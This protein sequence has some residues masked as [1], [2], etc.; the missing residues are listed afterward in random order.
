MRVKI[1]GD[2]C[3]HVI[4]NL[5]SILEGIKLDSI[6]VSAGGSAANV[7]L[8]LKKLNKDVDFFGVVGKDPLGDIFCN[9]LKE[10]HIHTD[11]I[12]REGKTH[13]VLIG[14]NTPSEAKVVISPGIEDIKLIKKYINHVEDGDIVY[15]P[16]F[17]EYEDIL[18]D[19]S[20][21]N[22]T[23]FTDYGHLSLGLEA[24]STYLDGLI[25]ISEY[26]DVVLASGFEF[27]KNICDEIAVS[28]SGSRC[29]LVIITFAGDGIAVITPKYQTYYKTNKLPVM[30]NVGA[31]DSF[32]AAVIYGYIQKWEIDEI[33]EFAHKVAEYKISHFNNFAT[34]KNIMNRR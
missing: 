16:G 23:V 31:G 8:Q 15:I 17:K 3:I 20:R 22:C 33:I 21:K 5:S 18:V 27:T 2:G 14:L 12:V 32:M 7:A 13:K 4:T 1:F 30:N 24:E 25:K 28:L 11:F 19:I 34:M 6:E 26:S 29:K 10:N 9:E